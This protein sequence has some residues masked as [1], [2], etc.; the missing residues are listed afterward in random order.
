MLSANYRIFMREIRL[1]SLPACEST[2]HRI[3]KLVALYPLNN[4]ELI[5]RLQTIVEGQTQQS[6]ADVFGHRTIAI[7]ATEFPAHLA[8]VEG[9]VMERA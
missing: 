1:K 4:A 6:L 3:S 8:Q 5:R 7:C 2:S 9:K